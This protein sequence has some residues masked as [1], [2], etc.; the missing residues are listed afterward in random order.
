MRSGETRELI[1][2][3]IPRLHANQDPKRRIFDV[4]L[5]GDGIERTRG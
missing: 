4:S 3:I 5:A 2:G 1:I